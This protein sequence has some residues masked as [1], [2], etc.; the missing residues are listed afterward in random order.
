MLVL[1]SD[2]SLEIVFMLL[3]GEN[4][5]NLLALKV[6]LT[7]SPGEKPSVLQKTKTTYANTVW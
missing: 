7:N 3:L 1:K 5:N 6:T 2:M 4:L